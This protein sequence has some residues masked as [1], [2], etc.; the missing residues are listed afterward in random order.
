[1]TK[2][3]IRWGCILAAATLVLGACSSSKKSS[4]SSSGTTA[5][6]AAAVTTEAPTTTAAASKQKVTVTPSDGLT[7][8]QIVHVVATGYTPGSNRGV[9]E[10]KAN[11]SGAGDCDLGAIKP[12]VID[13]SGTLTLDYKVK[14]SFGA[15]NIVCGG[16]TQCILDVNDLTAAPKEEASANINFK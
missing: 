16:T 3:I 4:A 2:T 9:I 14:K 8:G 5:T 13:A 12:A 7:D 11:A 1:M 10:C 15:N 6:T